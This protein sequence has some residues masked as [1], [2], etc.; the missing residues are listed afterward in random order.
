[1]PR[2]IVSTTLPALSEDLSSVKSQS[3]SRRDGR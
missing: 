2:S 3:G 1:V